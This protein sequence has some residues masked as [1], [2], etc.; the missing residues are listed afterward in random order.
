MIPKPPYRGGRANNLRIVLFGGEHPVKEGIHFDV[1]KWVHFNSN[2][3][4]R[5]SIHSK[6]VHNYT[7]YSTS[8]H[9]YFNRLSR[10]WNV[11]P[12]LN[13][14]LS[15]ATLKRQLNNI[16]WAM[17]TTNFDDNN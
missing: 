5:S 15:I 11:L 16:F 7:K 8:R 17:I 12:P 3:S 13:L 10:L 6:L 9:F 1:S 4:T 14:D 2:S